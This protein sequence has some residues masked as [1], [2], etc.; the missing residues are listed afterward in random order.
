MKIFSLLI[1]LALSGCAAT[2]NGLAGPPAAM[3][4]ENER[5]GVTLLGEYSYPSV[6]VSADGSSLASARLSVSDGTLSCEGSAS[7]LEKEVTTATLPIACSDGRTGKVILTFN[8]DMRRVD[9]TAVGVG[10]LSDGS[11]LKVMLGRITGSINW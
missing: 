3:K 7:Y 5:G 10:T 2:I 4:I 11:K 8:R 6:K 1:A 9:Q